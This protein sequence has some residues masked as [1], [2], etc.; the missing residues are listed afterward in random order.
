M[1]L[2][3]I[4][5]KHQDA[6]T[7][8]Q[9]FSSGSLQI[10][11]NE[12]KDLLKTFAEAVKDAKFVSARNALF[13]S[14]LHDPKQSLE[15]IKSKAVFRYSSFIGKKCIISGLAQEAIQFLDESPDAEPAITYF[16]TISN[17]S[18]ILAHLNEL[19]SGIVNEIQK[20]GKKYPKASMFKTLIAFVEF[21]FFTDY[22]PDNQEPDRLS[23]AARTKEDFCSAVS[24]L[25]FIIN[26][27]KP[28]KKADVR[29]AAPEFILSN[30]IQPIMLDACLIED[31]K[32][33]E[34]L[35]DHFGYHLIRE[36]EGILR[37]RPQSTEFEK[38]MRLG[39]IRHDLQAINDG[40]LLL[41][42]PMFEDAESIQNLGNLIMDKFPEYTIQFTDTM[43]YPRYVVGLPDGET[44]D[45][46]N[47][48]FAQN[49]L[50]QEEIYHLNKIFKEQLLGEDGLDKVLKGTLTL[51]EFIK[52]RRIMVMMEQ[53]MKKALHGLKDAKTADIIR[54]MVP[55]FD[56][57][58]LYRI[59]GGIV[60]EDKLE[61]FLDL[62]T[63]EPQMK[64]IFDIQY[65]NFIFIDGIYLLP[66]SVF[67]N[68][69]TVRNLYASQYKRNNTNL[70]SDGSVDSLT[71]KLSNTLAEAGL[72]QTV[73]IVYS[74]SELDL[75][76]LIDDMLVLIECKHT[77][78]PT[79][80]HELRT[81]YDYIQKAQSQLDKALAS[82]HSGELRTKLIDRFGIDLPADIRIKTLVVTSNRLLN[83]NLY[84]HP[85]RNI[86]ELTN[87]AENGIVRTNDG[88]FCL[89]QGERFSAIDLQLYLEE[90]NVHYQHMYTNLKSYE[91]AYQSDARETI[92][93]ESYY[94]N[95]QEAIDNLS[96]AIKDIPKFDNGL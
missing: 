79:S 48:Y 58:F 88:N 16:T 74:S 96:H 68:S 85:V 53:M 3:E 37:L 38:S 78:L 55:I 46:I 27:I 57:D 6:K 4:N 49:S 71:D 36:K 5:L 9:L 82:Y 95:M 13:I 69:N 34:I 61:D 30:E 65:H 70:L 23:Y 56:E 77:L 84:N 92:L 39:Y 73:N 21:L 24:Y 7:I 66:I 32:E 14:L 94:L 83:G 72:L 22:L 75:A 86:H 2:K 11:R 15:Y 44:R 59:L 45:I 12:H 28:L 62:L 43:D 87:L 8:K 26:S 29:F 93:Y 25:T 64:G 10:T 54:S 47:E 42:N 81:T 76:F 31:Y 18:F 51:L 20:F 41:N 33:I 52:I 67:S 40:M 60:S 80:V 19:K 90:K 35:I 89:W 50:F 1:T 91:T 17:F 63:W